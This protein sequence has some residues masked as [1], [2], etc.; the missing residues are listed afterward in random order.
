[1]PLSIQ[2]YDS[3]VKVHGMVLAHLQATF[4]ISTRFC[5]QILLILIY[6]YQLLASQTFINGDSCVSC[7][8]VYLPQT[9][10]PSGSA[11]SAILESEIIMINVII[12]ST[13]MF[14][15]R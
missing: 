3:V 15:C 10:L 4:K 12:N 5:M 2:T 9:R 13:D 8:P 14:V 1:M 7:L 6:L 11:C